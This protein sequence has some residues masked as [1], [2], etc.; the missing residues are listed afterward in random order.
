MEVI[1]PSSPGR[2]MAGFDFNDARP[3]PFLSAPASPRRFGDLTLSAP[4]SPGRVADF[5]RSFENFSEYDGGGVPFHWE[6][7]PGTPKSPK[8]LP[9]FKDEDF[10]FDFSADLE[11]SSLTAADELF[12]GGKI[13]PLKLPPRLLQVE[14]I[15]SPL[16]HSP[17]SPRSPIEQGKRI[18]KGAFA[19]SPR[20]KK[21]QAAA[22][23]APMEFVDSSNERGR[24]RNLTSSSSRRGAARS[25]SPYRVSQYPWEE[26]ERQFQ[27][28]QQQK[29]PEPEH[30]LQQTAAVSSSAVA[31]GKSSSRKWR[32]RDL[33]LFRSASE[34]RAADRDPYRKHAAFGGLFR[35]HDDVKSCSIRSTDS[36]GSNGGS[37]RRKGPVSAHELHYTKNK[38]ASEDM[39]KRTFLPY[40][41]GI[42]GMR[43]SFSTPS[44]AR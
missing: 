19:F 33:L 17:R 7:K 12:D 35:R 29:Q 10:A 31:T 5:Y 38:A 8:K 4:T 23:A 40:K 2:G 28:L 6:E 27:Q 24:G 16:I 39:K 20:R 37:L 9:S 1:I 30:N 26:E 42:L 41:Q 15:K 18:I 43:L 32:L 3:L 44:P 25:L 21:A 14:E 22:A 13:R 34:G 36:N 11:E